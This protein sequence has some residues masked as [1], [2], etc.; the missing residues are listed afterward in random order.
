MKAACCVSSVV[1]CNFKVGYLNSYAKK[2]LSFVFTLHP[3]PSHAVSVVV[4]CHDNFT[5]EVTVVFVL[6]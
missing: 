3:V 2:L 6:P 5:V 1:L 4:T